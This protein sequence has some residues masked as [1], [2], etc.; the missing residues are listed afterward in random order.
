MHLFVLPVIC[1][2]IRFPNIAYNFQSTNSNYA[3]IIFIISILTKE[4][5][6]LWSLNSE[7]KTIVEKLTQNI[8]FLLCVMSL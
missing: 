3:S 1:I 5:I 6:I 7:A 2:C 8:Y 4:K